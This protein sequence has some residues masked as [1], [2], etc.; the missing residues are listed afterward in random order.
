MAADLAFAC[1]LPALQTRF[2]FH[3][4]KLLRDSFD[5]ILAKTAERFV[6]RDLIAFSRTGKFGPDQWAFTPGLSA[7][8]LVTA[9]VIWQFALAIR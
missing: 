1:H 5:V 7:R 3:V 6:A 2:C 8:D 4:G 9:S